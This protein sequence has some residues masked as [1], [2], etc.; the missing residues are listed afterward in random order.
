MKRF[1][2]GV[3]MLGVLLAVSIWAMAAAG[4]VHT[5]ISEQLEEA[6]EESLAG[7]FFEGIL[8]ARQARQQWQ[9]HRE[10]V[11]AGANH[12]PMDEIDSLFAQAEVYAQTKQAVK[13]AACCARLSK[14]VEAMGESHRLSWWNIF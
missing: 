4:R 12:E 11:A 9:Q 8:L 2:I 3:G 1:W 5:P 10:S 13:F 6:A 14:L 7:D